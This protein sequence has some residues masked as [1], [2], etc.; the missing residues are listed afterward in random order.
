MISG[1]VLIAA[2]LLLSGVIATVGDRIGMRIG[3]ARL[4]LFNLRPRQTATLVSILTGGVISASTLA[5]LFG[6]SSQLR[7]SEK[8]RTRYDR[9][10]RTLPKPATPRKPLRLN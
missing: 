5:L 8:F 1:Y 4:S 7:S 9:Q 3:K 10:N 2:V 6:V